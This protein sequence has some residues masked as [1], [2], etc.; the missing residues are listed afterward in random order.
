MRH[1]GPSWIQHFAE[2]QSLSSPPIDTQIIPP[3][4]LDQAVAYFATSI[5]ETSA[6]LHTI[7]NH[8]EYLRSNHASLILKQ[9]ERHLTFGTAPNN[10]IT[11]TETLPIEQ[12]IDLQRST[13]STPPSSTAPIDTE[14]NA[15]PEEANTFPLD[16]IK[17]NVESLMNKFSNATEVE[18]KAWKTKS[19]KS[20]SR[21]F[22]IYRYIVETL[23]GDLNAFKNDAN[24]P[25][26]ELSAISDQWLSVI[27]GAVIK[28]AS[29]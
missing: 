12:L 29:S 11:I 21:Y 4:N 5:N 17:R 22:K 16:I 9:R 10:T 23:Q 20:Y 1:H 26:M 7:V 15:I 8:L 25:G 24:F 27:K 2:E 18:T 6:K 14:S 13:T 28:K 19:K 3:D